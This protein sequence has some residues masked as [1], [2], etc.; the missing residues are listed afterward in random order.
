MI[1]TALSPQATIVDKIICNTLAEVC[2]FDYIYN[3]P[4]PHSM[5]VLERWKAIENK[6]LTFPSDVTLFRGRGNGRGAWRR[7]GRGLWTEV[8]V[9][10]WAVQVVF[11][12]TILLA[13]IV[14]K[15]P[16]IKSRKSW[17]SGWLD[18]IILTRCKTNII[19]FNYYGTVNSGGE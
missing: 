4:S 1:Q 13:M 10:S 14:V 17:I 11:V 12:P 7:K 5:L 16:Q 8:Q 9:H 2:H 18:S 19:L 15:F 3:T 6:S